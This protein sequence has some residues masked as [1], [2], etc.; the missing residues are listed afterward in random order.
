MIIESNPRKHPKQESAGVLKLF[1][2]KI[3]TNLFVCMARYI[4]RIT[5][6]FTP[7]KDEAQ[8]VA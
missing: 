6:I 5:L 1:F 7:E 3:G 2:R 8:I 4:K